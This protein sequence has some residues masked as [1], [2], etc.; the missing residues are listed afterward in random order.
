MSYSD[1]T[2]LRT[3]V[4]SGGGSLPASEYLKKIQV[5][6][7]YE[8]PNEI[9][10]YMRGILVDQRPT[11]NNLMAHEEKRSNTHANERMSM[12][13]SGDTTRS[14]VS[15]NL[16]DGTFLDHVF[17]E[18][19]PRGHA[20][21]PDF[22]KMKEQRVARAS[23]IN[24][25]NDADYSVPEQGINP[26]KMIANKKKLHYAFKDR[27]QNFET[28]LDGWT[29]PY[30]K[31]RRKGG[32]DVG[33]YTMD[34]TLMDLN[35]VSA[36]NRMDATAIL[37][38]D[39]KV[40]WRHS[41]PDHR[42]KIAQ[43]GRVSANQLQRDNDW[44]NN[45]GSTFQDHGVSVANEGQAINKQFA[46]MIMSLEGQQA[47]KHEVAQGAEY[48]EGFN[49]IT[50]RNR[51]I[52]PDDVYK[53]IM[54]GMIKQSHAENPHTQISDGTKIMRKTGKRYHQNR[55]MTLQHVRYNHV[56][57]EAMELATRTLIHKKVNDLR[58]DVARSAADN[59]I[60]LH[61]NTR[62]VQNKRKHNA[63]GDA[64]Y[65]HHIEKTKTVKNYG[66]IRPNKTNRAMEKVA[67]EKFANQSHDAKFR[68]RVHKKKNI[69]VK[70]YKQTQNME[71]DFGV[72]D[73]AK[74]EDSRNHMGMDRIQDRGDTEAG[75]EFGADEF[76]SM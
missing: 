55:D 12:R 57:A 27:W 23:L 54:I 68:A 72:Y 43:Y 73:K 5:S 76:A 29:N 19:D 16:P 53:A 17:M 3:L 32:S 37:S 64:K 75:V 42:F 30:N 38:N 9:E 58:D 71:D 69:N 59:G 51:K 34:G 65:D 20:I 60:Y 4:G 45:R 14:G 56:I 36:G 49:N 22:N 62:Q 21:G 2:Q 66:G 24:F 26:A 74:K 67:F 70:N 39:P 28:S 46:A 48:G 7:F 31:S 41:T 44:G 52:H 11:K 50:G 35:D 10:N 6:D 25:G 47:T 15:P 8:D 1:G 61:G 40:A 63:V 18:R 33:K 13:Y